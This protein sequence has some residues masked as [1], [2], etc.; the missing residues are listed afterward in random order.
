MTVESRS[1]SLVPEEIGKVSY[2]QRISKATR[3][4]PSFAFP[5]LLFKFQPYKP[6][7]GVALL[8]NVL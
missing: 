4:S 2:D 1:E 8:E 7:D 5:V 3:L 6:K